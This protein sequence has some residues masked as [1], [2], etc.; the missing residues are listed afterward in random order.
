M[1]NSVDFLPFFVFYYK[2][3]KDEF[4]REIEEIQDKNLF[5]QELIKIKYSYDKYKKNKYL[6]YND[7]QLDNNLLMKYLNKINNLEKK[8]FNN[9]FYMTNSINHNQPDNILVIAIMVIISITGVISYTRFKK[10]RIVK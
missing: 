2:E 6:L 1:T 4:E 7:Y 9:I 3:F 8:Q 10:Y 5:N